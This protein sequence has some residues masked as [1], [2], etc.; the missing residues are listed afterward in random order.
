MKPLLLLAYVLAGGINELD[1]NHSKFSTLD[2]DSVC[3]KPSLHYKVYLERTAL[4]EARVQE[5]LVSPPTD[6][7]SHSSPPRPNKNKVHSPI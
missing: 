5:S 2:C 3:L 4:A 1:A 7:C 6:D